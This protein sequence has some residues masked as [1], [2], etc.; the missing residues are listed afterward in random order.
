MNNKSAIIAAKNI[1]KTYISAIARAIINSPQIV[2]TDEPTGSLNQEYGFAIL[3]I[4]TEMNRRGQS[5][6]MVTHDIKV[7]CR[8]DRLI[9]F[10]DGAIA[11]ILELDKCEESDMPK[12]ESK[13]FS[14]LSGK[15]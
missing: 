5:V 1:S 6:V 13:I 2:F 4:I 15:E 3:N 9:Y 8:A 10:K 7:A 11:G 12:R 14:Y